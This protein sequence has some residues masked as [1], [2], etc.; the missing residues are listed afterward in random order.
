[1]VLPCEYRNRYDCDHEE[2]QADRTGHEDAQAAVGKQHCAAEIIL[3]QRAKHDAEQNRNKLEIHAAQEVRNNAE[4]QDDI[5]II[6]SV[7]GR[8]RTGDTERQNDACQNFSPNL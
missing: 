4:N 1:M 5:N 2:Q 8:V 7:V 3:S 6:Q